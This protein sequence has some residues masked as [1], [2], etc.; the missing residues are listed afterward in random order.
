[1]I[2]AS[3]ILHDFL[4]PACGTLTTIGILLYNNRKLINQQKVMHAANEAT[5][6]A[7][8]ESTNRTLVEHGERLDSHQV[9]FENL[10]NEYVPRTEVQSRIDGVQA[11]I[12]SLHQ[13]LQTFLPIMLARVV[14]GG[15]Y[16]MPEMPKPEEKK[17]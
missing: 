4:I 15:Y 8:V 14:P 5:H 9:K 10:K 12:A 6:A 17:S 16:P 1:M 7:W 3:S 2:T 13:W 11:S